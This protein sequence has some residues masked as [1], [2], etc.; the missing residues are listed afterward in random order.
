VTKVEKVEYGRCYGARECE[1]DR[2]AVELEGGY[3]SILSVNL[4]IVY[5]LLIYPAVGFFSG[6]SYSQG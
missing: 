1:T 6:H 2:R 4:F 5:S 3:W